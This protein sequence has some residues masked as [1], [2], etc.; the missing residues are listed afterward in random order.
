EERDL[1]GLVV[2]N[3]L[4]DRDETVADALYD[5]GTRL[6]TL[7]FSGPDWDYSLVERWLAWR[8]SKNA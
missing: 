3:E 1:S 2:S 7:G 6:F 4:K 5:A 8:D